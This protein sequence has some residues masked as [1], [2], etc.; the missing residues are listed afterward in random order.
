MRV[1]SNLCFKDLCDNK[2]DRISTI[3]FSSCNRIDSC[4]CF[5]IIIYRSKS[6]YPVG[7]LGKKE[8]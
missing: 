6:L 8:F 4:K 7:L 1:V 2:T 3:E 5:Y